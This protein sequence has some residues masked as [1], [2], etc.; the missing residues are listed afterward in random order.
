MLSSLEESMLPGFGQGSV[1]LPGA[2]ILFKA[3][4]SEERVALPPCGQGWGLR[5]KGRETQ[6]R[7]EAMA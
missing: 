6:S 3:T 7:F 5:L 1:D 4:M 2:Q